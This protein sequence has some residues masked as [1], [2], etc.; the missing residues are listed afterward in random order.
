MA[1]QTMLGMMG[2]T[3]SQGTVPTQ[4]FNA[5][6]FIG[7][8]VPQVGD[9]AARPPYAGAVGGIDANHVVLT[10]VAVF[11]IGYLLYHFNFEK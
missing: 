8:P 4:T 7:T 5:A 11:A 1:Y 2:R 3:D 10:A 6:N 9:S